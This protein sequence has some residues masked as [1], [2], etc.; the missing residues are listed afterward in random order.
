M[1]NFKEI[2]LKDMVLDKQEDDGFLNLFGA[3]KKRISKRN[4][5]KV[6]SQFG[7]GLPKGASCRDIDVYIKKIENEIA[8]VRGKISS[9]DKSKFWTKALSRLEDILKEAKNRRVIADCDRI[10]EEQEKEAA[11]KETLILLQKTAESATAQDQTLQKQEAGKPV[12]KDITKYIAIGVAAIFA[13]GGV[14]ILLKPSK[15]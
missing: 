4:V 12:K 13:L 2:E 10:I 7:D 8:S 6:E 5:E 15:K 14:F 3:K 9:G 1:A 11:Q